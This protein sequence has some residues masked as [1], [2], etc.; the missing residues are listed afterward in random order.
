[1]TNTSKPSTSCDDRRPLT[2]GL[3]QNRF[4]HRK[5]LPWP[6]ESG[7]R[8]LGP[9][10]SRLTT[11]T[12]LVCGKRTILLSRSEELKEESQGASKSLSS[13]RSDA[14]KPAQ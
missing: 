8:K 4:L 2:K 7:V 6:Q 9:G 12:H 3:A 14:G 5:A 11:P 13:R 10:K 1:M